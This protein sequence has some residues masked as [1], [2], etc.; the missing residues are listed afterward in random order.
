[1]AHLAF[2]YVNE[3]VNC[4]E[5]FIIDQLLVLLVK[6]LRLR[7]GGGGGGEGRRSNGSLFVVIMCVGGVDWVNS[8]L[9]SGLHGTGAAAACTLRS[10]W[11]SGGW[12]SR[13]APS[14][15]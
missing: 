9:K 15:P 3:S 7:V 8:G 2:S 1:M 12:M 5:L 14:E 10:G 6:K 11:V 4:D 13:R